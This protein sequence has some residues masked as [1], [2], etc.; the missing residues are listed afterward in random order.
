MKKLERRAALCLVLAGFLLAGLAVFLFR[1]AVDGSR[2]A[3]SPFNRHLYN[4]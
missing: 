1:F 2:W 4:S 3:S